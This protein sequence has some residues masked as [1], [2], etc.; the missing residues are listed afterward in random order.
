MSAHLDVWLRELPRAG[1]SRSAPQELPARLA[2]TIDC[3]ARYFP[4]EPMAYLARV[5][6]LL[7]SALLPQKGPYLLVSDPPA[8][9][10]RISRCRAWELVY[11]ELSMLDGSRRPLRDLHMVLVGVICI[12]ARNESPLTI[13]PRWLASLFEVLSRVVPLQMADN[14]WSVEASPDM[15]LDCQAYT[16]WSTKKNPIESHFRF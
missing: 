16:G 4:D 11:L 1:L 9:S 7:L 6:D 13:P 10:E 5:K 14:K 12:V 15:D 2:A 3:R 8:A